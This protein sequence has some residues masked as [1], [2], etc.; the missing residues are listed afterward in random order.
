MRQ[1]LLLL[2]ASAC[3]AQDSFLIRDVR[4]F[5]GSAVIE[6]TS[7]LIAAGT[8]REIRPGLAAPKGEEV[9]DGSGK[10]LLPGLIDA[11]AHISRTVDLRQALAFGTTTELD[12]FSWPAVMDLFRR[13]ERG[14][15]TAQMSDARF[16]G[17][18]AT[19]PSGHGTESDLPIPVIRAPE[20]AQPFVD[21]RIREG[22]DYI[23]IIYASVG[24]SGRIGLPTISR[25]TLAA[26]V[27]AAHR[28]GKLAVVHIGTLQ[29]AREAV[30]AGVD[31]L[32]HIFSGGIADPEFGALA[33]R[34]GT[35]VVPTL[36]IRSTWCNEAPG[37]EFAKDPRFAADLMPSAIKSLD[38]KPPAPS[39]KGCEG[40]PRTLPFLREAGVPILAGTD[41]LN[42]SIAH[43]VSL[44]GEMAL[45]VE[46]GLTPREAL[47]A[48]T[49]APADAFHLSDRG[50][51]APGKRADLLLVDG[52]PV[53]DIRATRNIS[54]VWKQG[55]LFDRAAYR[56]AVKSFDTP[57]RPAG[58]ESG[59]LSDFEEP[60]IA[61]RFGS[62]WFAFDGVRMELEP[63][64]ANGTHHSVGVSGEV[65]PGRAR[66]FWP[67]IIATPA[68]ADLGAMLEADL[69]AWKGIELWA[70]GD[71]QTYRI[72][73]NTDSG[74]HVR[75][76]V[77]NGVWERYQFLFDDFGANTSRS[78]IGIILAAPDKPGRYAF[79]VDEVRLFH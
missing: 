41:S 71:G 33:K 1:G 68:S 35:F 40:G 63:D 53:L 62:N 69:S 58:S 78:V 57:V 65:E 50:R 22:S 37:Q 46:A 75:T 31:G 45:L 42:R 23:K 12:M 74:H 56:A 21:A 26:L 64:G 49:A 4:V 19:A 29:E 9:V 34:H 25:E 44:H 67:G 61:T 39:R 11:H 55:H 27:S 6:R 36:S 17:I 52:N 18:C 30:E 60:T 51:I 14:D 73:L 47:V 3:C 20:E 79:R 72:I 13:M 77:A 32:A 48:A 16:A 5:D 54:A 15:Q 28:R 38:W 8:V 66:T 7:V 70:K 10:T 59:V 24:R 43:G 2:L 76:F